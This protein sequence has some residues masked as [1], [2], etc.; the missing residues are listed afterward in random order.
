[1][2]QYTRIYSD[3]VTGEIRHVC[4][5]DTPFSDGFEPII[6]AETL[7]KED[8]EIDHEESR[9]VSANEIISAIERD[10]Q[11][12][13]SRRDAPAFIQSARITVARRNG[14]DVPRPVEESVPDPGIMRED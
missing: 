13:R 14:I 8:V 1:M 10:G 11:T 7:D 4:T 12:L 6:T 5:Q 3:P 2:K 9:H